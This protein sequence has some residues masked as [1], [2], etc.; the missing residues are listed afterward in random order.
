MICIALLAIIR[1]PLELS[2][3]D[4]LGTTQMQGPINATWH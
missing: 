2:F 3:L 1:V 4:W